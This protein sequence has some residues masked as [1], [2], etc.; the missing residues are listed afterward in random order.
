M[1]HVPTRANGGFPLLTEDTHAKKAWMEAIQSAIDE[2]RASPEFF[3][4]PG[5]YEADDSSSISSGDSD[6]LNEVYPGATTRI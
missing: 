6:V 5:L 3:A 1:L 2:Y 4:A